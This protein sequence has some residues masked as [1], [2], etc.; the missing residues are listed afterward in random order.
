MPRPRLIGL[1]IAVWS[2]VVLLAYHSPGDNPEPFHAVG[3]LRLLVDVARLSLIAGAA[4][5][6]GAAILRAFSLPAVPRLETAILCLGAGL[7]GLAIAV[8]LVSALGILRPSVLAGLITCGVLLLGVEAMRGP[9]RKRVGL[10][11][12]EA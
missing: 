9:W 4:W 1:L 10:D 6:L 3:L 11:R 7:G 12:R 2:L 8:L 5:G